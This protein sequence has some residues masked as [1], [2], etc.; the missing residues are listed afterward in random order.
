[1]SGRAITARGDNVGEGRKEK[2]SGPT[3]S[4]RSMLKETE[5]ELETLTELQGLRHRKV[6]NELSFPPLSKLSVAFRMSFFNRQQWQV[7]VNCNGV[8]VSRLLLG[9]SHLIF[10]CRCAAPLQHLL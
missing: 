1:M 8:P 9:Q 3:N 10:L 5:I 4:G 6:K 7:N 2:I